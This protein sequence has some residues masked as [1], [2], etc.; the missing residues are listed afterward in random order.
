MKHHIGRLLAGILLVLA[1]SAPSAFAT[2]ATVR[3][4]GNTMAGTVVVNTTGSGVPGN[5][6]CQPNS[7][8]EALDKATLGNWDRQTYVSTILGESHTYTHND[9]WAFWIN[10]SYSAVQGICDYIVQPGDEILL[11]PQVDGPGFQGTVFPLYFAS[12]PAAVS[13]GVPYTVSVIKRVSDG[14]TT[15]S[16]PAVGVTVDDGTSTATTDA[17]GQATLTTSTP[18]A[19]Q[20][21]AYGPNAVNSPRRTVTAVAPAAAAAPAAPT[22]PTPTEA[23]PAPVTPD[24]PPVVQPEPSVADTKAPIATIAGLRNRQHFRKGKGPRE[25]KGSVADGGALKS[26]EVRLRR[27]AGKRCFAFNAKRERFTRTRCSRG[28]AWFSVGAQADWSYL[29]PARL[30]AGLYQLQVRAT[31][32][33][34]NQSSVQS[35]RFRVA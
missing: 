34:G 1:V 14:T 22:A 12:V 18:G 35:L 33:A 5:A 26:V 7:A 2:P 15:T 10:G 17:N 19:F 16:Q 20:L 9:Y 23:P 8:A 32:A 30:R 28:A 24:T 3:I 27:K 31:D 6:T 29:L 21:V 4:E 25:L 11:Y 13:A